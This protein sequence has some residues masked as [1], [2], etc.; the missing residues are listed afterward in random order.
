MVQLICIMGTMTLLGNS[1]NPCMALGISSCHKPDLSA[2]V[3]TGKAGWSAVRRHCCSNLSK[4]AAGESGKILVPASTSQEVQN[5]PVLPW[6][7]GLAPLERPLIE[8]GQ[9]QAEARQ[10]TSRIQRRLTSA[11]SLH[12][13]THS[14]VRSRDAV[15]LR[16]G[17]NPTLDPTPCPYLMVISAMTLLMNRGTPC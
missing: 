17:F 4:T 8:A 2:C 15:A 10:G 9:P 5:P 14:L 12:L 7:P 3:S 11:R 16:K 1:L 6:D 13:L